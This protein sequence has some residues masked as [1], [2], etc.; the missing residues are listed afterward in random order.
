M[1]LKSNFIHVSLGRVSHLKGCNNFFFEQSLK[2]FYTLLIYYDGCVRRNYNL[3]NINMAKDFKV[4]F[5]S[6]F[7]SELKPFGGCN[8]FLLDHIFE[9]FF[10][11]LSWTLVNIHRSILD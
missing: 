9:S 2:S 5:Y 6:Y 8:N 11:M 4:K 7:F 1:I 3:K 10:V